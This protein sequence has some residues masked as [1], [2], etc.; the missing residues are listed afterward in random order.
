MSGIKLK[1]ISNIDEHLFVE[2]W[3][4]RCISYIAKR[5]SKANNKYMTYHGS[6][7]ESKFIFY[8]DANI[9]YG[10]AMSQYLSNGEFKWLNQK[11]DKFGVNSISGNSSDGNILEVDLE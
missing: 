4:R 7:E 10:W 6:W 11:N 5:Y 1:L 9:S 8:L 3:M 2:K